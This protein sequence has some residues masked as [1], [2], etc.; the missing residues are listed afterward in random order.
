M[1]NILITGASGFIG[2]NLI[3]T[4]IKEDGYSVTGLDI[5]K[6]LSKAEGYEFIEFDLG[7]EETYPDFKKN[8]D[9]VI[10]LAQSPLYRDFPNSAKSIFDINVKSTAY[11]L[12]WCRKNKVKKFIFASTGN[13][14]KTKD[15]LL[16]EDDA[17]SPNSYY[18]ASKY[19][20]ELF[21]KQYSNYFSVIILRIFGV[22]GPGQKGMLIQNIIDKII[23][24]EQ[25][26]LAKNIGIKITPIYV[27]DCVH[28]IKNII[29]YN[30]NNN[31]EVFNLGGH[32][33]LTLKGIAKKIA[34]CFSKDC[35]LIITSDEPLYLCSNN[36][37]IILKLGE[38]NN[39]S[40][41]MGL[42]KVIEYINA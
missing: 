28:T 23:N 7:K 22:Y 19:A 30:A 39:H 4:L 33:I 15:A 31:I 24:N 2:S 21:A 35:N 25:I 32:E 41:D 34:D 17:I 13:V 9:T 42:K 18:A 3:N 29:N 8:I 27:S 5:K 10:H 20:S 6:P 11:L 40:F 37:K 26:F 38:I 1:N 16:K 36:N 14:Y 12:E